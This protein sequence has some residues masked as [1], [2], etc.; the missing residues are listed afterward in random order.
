MGKRLLA[1]SDVSG[2]AVGQHRC[3]SACLRGRC[4]GKDRFLTTFAAYKVESRQR[5]SEGAISYWRANG[6]LWRLCI[7]IELWKKEEETNFSCFLLLCCNSVGS[8]CTVVLSTSRVNK[9]SSR[10]KGLRKNET[11]SAQ[12]WAK[13][14]LENESIKKVP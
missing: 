6:Q 10:E 7:K 12:K 13:G 4:R 3:R 1:M 14:L 2:A 11:N 5:S 9:G 8:G